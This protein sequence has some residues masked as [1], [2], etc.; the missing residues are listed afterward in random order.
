MDKA[1]D[2]PW[3]PLYTASRAGQPEVSV[4]GIAY[5]WMEDAALYANAGRSLLKV[6]QVNQPLWSRSLLKPWQLMALYPVLRKAYPALRDEHLAMMM[7]SH[8][9]D[10]RQRALL[11]E[12]LALADLPEA[13]VRC[14]ACV[15]MKQWQSSEMARTPLN[16][17]CAGKHVAHLMYLKAQGSD[18]TTYLEAN[19]EPYVRQRD[20][21]GYLLN[22]SFPAQA[23]DGCGMPN[24]A[25]SAVELAQL[26]HALSRPLSQSL[27]NQAPEEVEEMIA[28]LPAVAELMRR[29]PELI[30]GEGRLDSRLMQ[31]GASCGLVAKEGADGLL[32]LGLRDAAHYP[33]GLGMLVKLASGYVPEHLE[34][35]IVSLG[36][37]LG[38]PW[39]MNWPAKDLLLQDVAASAPVTL[40]VHAR[41]LL[42]DSLLAHGESV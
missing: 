24:E 15:P 31:A 4:Y 34:T 23:V 32:V 41:I 12:I 8:Q 2:L 25:L 13:A 6:G 14:P 27:L 21:L 38:L 11:R 39:A 37:Q 29:Y 42:P 36:R 19:A 7:A 20:L 30:G 22:R 33:D 5:V 10:E 16:H 17:P 1:V 40:Q 9:G 35:L 3:A 18:W 28:C 26:Y